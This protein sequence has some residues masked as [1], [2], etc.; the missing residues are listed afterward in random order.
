MEEALKKDGKNQT[1]QPTNS[2]PNSCLFED[3]SEFR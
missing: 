3:G 1:N 2:F